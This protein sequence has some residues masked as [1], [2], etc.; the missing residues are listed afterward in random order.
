MWRDRPYP[1]FAFPADDVRGVESQPIDD[2]PGH[3]AVAWDAV[4]EWLD[5]DEPLVA[6]ARDP[7]HRI[8]VRHSSR[9]VLIEHEGEVIAESRRPLLLYETGLPLR[10]Y[11]PAE[12][13]RGLTPSPTRTRCAYK[14]EAEHLSHAGTDVAW[15]YPEPLFDAPPIGGL[16]GFYGERVDLI[17]DGERQE[18]PL[19]PWS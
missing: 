4:D 2:V 7:F 11:L 5:D 9:H 10:F 1:F 3:V 14:G 13:V 17:V 15:V 16:I 8:D 12:D 18:R 6:H 19:T